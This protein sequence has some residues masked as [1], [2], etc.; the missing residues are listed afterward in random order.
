MLIPKERKKIFE[1][2]LK[3]PYNEIHLRKIARLSSVSLT[4]VHNTM[5]SLAKDSMFI[6]KDISNMSLFKADICNESLLKVFESLELEKRQDFY[7]K[8]KNIAR[9]LQKY[10]QSIIN[11]S[12]KKIQ[13]VVLFGSVARSQWDKKSDIDILAVSPEKKNG[14]TAVLDKAKTEVSPLLQINPVSTSIE[15]FQEGIRK[16]TEFYNELWNDRIILYN[17]FLFWQLVKEGAE[18]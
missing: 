5:N 1:I 14:I 16:R 13:L 18:R 3:D 10:T 7:N 9:L 4:N 6:K 12:G 15:K 8:N 17:E 11:L 2:F